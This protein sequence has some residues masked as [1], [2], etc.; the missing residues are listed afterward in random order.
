[1]SLPDNFTSQIGTVALSASTASIGSVGLTPDLAVGAKSITLTLA[2]GSGAVPIGD[3]VHIV[4]VKPT[5]SGSAGTRIGLEAPEAD[6]TATGTAA[7][8]ALKKGV[9]VDAAVWTWFQVG[10]GTGRTLYVKGGAS[11]VIEVVE[12]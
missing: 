5:A 9:P 2:S 1:M 11:D 4:G 12:L 10:T 8:S 7:A 3:G 6:G